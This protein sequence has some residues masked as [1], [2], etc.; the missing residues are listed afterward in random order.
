M[1]IGIPYD[2]S[3]LSV[4]EENAL[5]L[6]HWNSTTNQWEDKTLFVDTFNDIIFGEV[7]SLSI[8]TIIL[9][10]APPSISVET[11]FEGQALQDGITFKINV[12]DSSEIDLVTISIRELGGDQVFVGQATHIIDDEWQLPFDTTLLPDGYYQ[13]IIESSDIIGNSGSAPPVNVS[14]RNWATLELLPATIGNK[15]GRTMPVKF[16]LRVVEAVDPNM[17]FVR[18]E[19]LDIKIY[20]KSTGQLLQHSTLGDTSRDYRIKMILKFI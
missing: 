1:I 5:V 17:A 19:E 6:V 20:D 4:E 10:I 13:I 12:T 15:A 8:F 9:D 16:S 7:E 18:N 14:I 2:G 3:S 11:P